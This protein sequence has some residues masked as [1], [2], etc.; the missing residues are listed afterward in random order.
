MISIQSI[1]Y[2]A[3]KNGMKSPD[4]DIYAVCLFYYLVNVITVLFEIP[5]MIAL[6]QSIVDQERGFGSL[7]LT[8]ILVATSHYASTAF[9]THQ[10]MLVSNIGNGIREKYYALFM[11]ATFEWLEKDENNVHKRKEAVEGCASNCAD[12]IRPMLRFITQF[13][14]VAYTLIII[15]YNIGVYIIPLFGMMFVFYRYYQIG[16][17]KAYMDDYAIHATKKNS[18]KSKETMTHINGHDKLLHGESGSYIVNLI[19]PK[20]MISNMLF[21]LDKKYLTFWCL[22]SFFP[23]LINYLILALALWDGNYGIA[24]FVLRNK[25]SFYSLIGEVNEFYTSYK[26]AV[27]DCEPLQKMLKTIEYKDLSIT[28]PVTFPL[29]IS[30]IDLNLFNGATHLRQSGF[31]EINKKSRILFNGPS[32]IG[33]TVLMKYL[34]GYF[35][36]KGEI[37]ISGDIT[38]Q[39]LIPH[40]SLFQC[41]KTEEQIRAGCSWKELIISDLPY[42]ETIFA[43]VVRT[44]K[45]H[46]KIESTGGIDA[47]VTD[48]L[49]TGECTRFSLAKALYRVLIKKLSIIFMDEPDQGLQE[50]LALEIIQNIF[51]L[52]VCL[53]MSLHFESVKNNLTF[54]DVVTFDESNKGVFSCTSN[55][56]ELI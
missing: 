37:T 17:Q 52:D 43:K 8:I 41:S 33:K 40:R 55:N 25:G 36:G 30:N 15:S 32:G 4:K 46:D 28:K 7:I 14:T 19:K 1:I 38:T 44:T 10:T 39:D 13:V 20:N 42:D 9:Y 11:N 6:S 26:M 18:F 21:Q 35:H 2:E 50:P 31:F 23:L 3:I 48:G 54:T 34:C 27:C 16:I 56:W 24:L 53:I 12:V 45:I 5:V 47:D 51:K 29:L 49:S 22:N